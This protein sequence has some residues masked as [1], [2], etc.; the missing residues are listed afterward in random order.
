MTTGN[1]AKDAEKDEEGTRPRRRVGIS[2]LLKTNI[3][4]DIDI[5]I[6]TEKAAEPR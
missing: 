3:D 6:S 5:D 1:G 4:I 2:S